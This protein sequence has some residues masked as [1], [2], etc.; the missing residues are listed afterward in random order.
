M[1]KEM[2]MQAELKIAGLD[3]VFDKKIEEAVNRI[4]SAY[5]PVV[6]ELVEL[7]EMLKSKFGFRSDSYLDKKQVAEIIGK[8]GKTGVYINQ[9]VSEGKFPKPDK[10]EMGKFPRW[11]VQTIKDYLQKQD[12]FWRWN[13]W[14][15]N[16]IKRRLK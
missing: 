6:E 14:E 2:K 3:E 9:L 13:E 7:K 4:E 15:S 12:E 11:K 16:N 1:Q 8:G 10:Y 5:R